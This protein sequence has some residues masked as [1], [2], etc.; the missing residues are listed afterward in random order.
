MYVLSKCALPLLSDLII[1]LGSEVRAVIGAYYSAFLCL[2]IP[3]ATVNPPPS[4]VIVN[5]VRIALCL[6]LIAVPALDRCHNV[7]RIT[8]PR[9]QVSLIP[10]CVGHCNASHKQKLWTR[11]PATNIRAQVLPPR[12]S[13][14]QIASPW[15]A[16]L[17]K[18]CTFSVLRT[19]N[20]WQQTRVQLPL[21][22]VL[23]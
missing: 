22:E 19:V 14:G 12:N 5:N 9:F 18:V 7:F 4:S 13:Q 21:S 3:S 8:C 17:I 10:Y 20:A 23:T 6:C 11:M 16:Q 2:H 1:A 15:S